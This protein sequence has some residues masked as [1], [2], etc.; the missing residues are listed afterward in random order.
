MP[1]PSITEAHK[2]YQAAAEEL[3]QATRDAFPVGTL[4]SVATSQGVITC[5]VTGVSE[6]WWHN[7]GTLLVRNTKT[8]KSRHV[9]GR[10]AWQEITILPAA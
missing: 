7:P 2:A 9:L 6:S 10:T 5:E 4:V 1:H 8:G 3:I